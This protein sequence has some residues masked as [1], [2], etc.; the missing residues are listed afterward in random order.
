MK[1][2][3]YPGD[4]I[5]ELPNKVATLRL[6]G[7]C[8]FQLKALPF[9]MTFDAAQIEAFAAIAREG[10]L[11]RAAQALNVTQPALSRMIQRLER[12]LGARLFER[13]SKGMMLT[14]IGEAF[15]PHA[16]LLR[17]EAE[18][19][20][21]EIDAM[22]GVARGVARIGVVAS[23][24]CSTLPQ[25][26]DRVLVSAPRLRFEILEGVWDV[27]SAAL[28]KREID[29]AFAADARETDEIVAV[30]LGGW[31]DTSCIVAAANHPLRQVQS[32]A[33]ADLAGAR[34]ALP[35]RGAQP[36]RQLERLFAEH[37]LGLP[38]ITV[39]TRS[40]TM[41]KSLVLSSGFLAWMAEPMFEAERR[42]GLID[43]LP[44]AG[45]RVE[46][47]LSAFRRR[48]GVLPGPAALLLKELGAIVA[49]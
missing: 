19:A 18:R 4:V 17:T 32:L 26:I 7:N 6:V 10:S 31:T 43:A 14:D 44:A 5:P 16:T 2:R 27:L 49:G 47:R 15:L 29:L 41:L 39:E 33:I 20:Q 9:G 45:A 13:Y 12:R 42:A 11:G 36:Y 34:W 46:R 23:V 1:G 24:A 30:P 3:E 48:R 38:E 28:T 35:P 22:R 25:A 37:G 40:I 21:E 8:R